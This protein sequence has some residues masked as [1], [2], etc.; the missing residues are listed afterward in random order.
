[1]EQRGP[2]D[3]VTRRHWLAVCLPAGLAGCSGVGSVV[4][5]DN[6][7]FADQTVA[8]QI[9]T[10]TQDFDR[11][12]RL[13]TDALDYWNENQQPLSYTTTLSYEPDSD[14]PD[15]FV[16]EVQTIDGCEVHTGE[17]ISGCAP[18]L[19]PGSQGQLPATL[20]LNPQPP[21]EDWHYRRVIEHELGHLL[22]LTHDDEPTAIMH[23]SW[24]ERYPQYERRR[25][26]FELRQQRTDAYNQGVQFV[27]D[28]FDAAES[29]RFELAS[30]RFRQ[31]TQAY[32]DAEE[33]IAT[34]KT[35]T[36]ALAPFEPADRE[37]LAA[38]LETETEFVETALGGLAPMIEGTE[39]LA[40]GDERGASRYNDGVDAYREATEMDI[41]D[42]ETYLTA[43]G[44]PTA[45]IAE[46]ES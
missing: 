4:G 46:T 39:S 29:D 11:L 12:E 35:V 18:I 24:T 20:E 25:H 17:E 3:P 9:Q 42:P 40:A 26:V 1:M 27:S 23:A 7:P 41:P 5:P 6:H 34:S 36:A 13:V 22:G 31:A 43:V 2:L 19:T 37:R 32:Q 8:V 16:S 38:L 44:F 30:E 15:V 45:I 14:E 10:A 28:G 33:T 21:G